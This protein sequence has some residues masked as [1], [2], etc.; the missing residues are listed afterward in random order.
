M[1]CECAHAKRRLKE[2]LRFS[3]SKEYIASK[4]NNMSLNFIN[5]QLRLQSKQS[6]GRRFSIEDKIFALSLMKQRPKAYRLLK[7]T[8][9]LP[10]RRTLMALLSRVPIYCGIN[11]PVEL[12]K[13]RSSKNR[14]N[15][16]VL[17][18]YV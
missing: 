17:L 14:P 1:D 2:A 7:R 6:R 3:E 15:G 9:A 8:F 11:K 18:S 16:Q 12:P 10:S 4:V 13:G 5:S